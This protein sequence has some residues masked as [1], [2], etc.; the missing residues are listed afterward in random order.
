MREITIGRHPDNKIVINQSDIS[1][2]HAVIEIISDGNVLIKDLNSTN[3]TFVNDVK[4]LQKFISSTDKVQLSN[5]ELD[6][7]SY[8]NSNKKIQVN[9]TIVSEQNQVEQSFSI[10][11]SQTCNHVIPYP[12][13]SSIHA[14]LI[15]QGNSIL[16]VDNQSTNGTYVNGK[17]ILE[18]TLCKGDSLLLSNKYPVDWENLMSF[19]S[20]K[21][22]NKSSL[23]ITGISVAVLIFLG[24]LFHRPLM[25]Q[26]GRWF[27]GIETNVNEKYKNSVVLIY[28]TYLYVLESN[29]G[30][31]YITKDEQGNFCNYDPTTNSPLAISGTG[32]FVS[33]NGDIITNRHVAKP[34]EMNNDMELIRDQ[35]SPYIQDVSS[36]RISGQ[37]VGISIAL[38]DSYV[39]S[40]ND[41]I[42]CVF[43]KDSGD[44]QIDV[45]LL[46]TKT[47]TLPE[48]VNTYID[49]S[50]AVTNSVE[51]KIGEPLFMIGYP[52]GFDLANT[53]QGIMANFQNGQLTRLPDGI[54]FGH[55]LPTMGGASGSPIFNKHGQLMGINYQG[56][57]GTQGFNMAMLAKYVCEL[58][59]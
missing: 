16:V 46:Q 51:I 50:N 57:S 15:R 54:D 29:G 2:H 23:L 33:A 14:K 35:I 25:E 32:F 52:A 18:H 45:A 28:H 30:T 17:R 42:P 34:W 55:N 38:N 53:K 10:G 26:V 19:S 27:P 58:F 11:R 6:L 1:L 40:V 21:T 41:M 43:I 59:N 20:H 39:E 31:L 24:I 5:Y 7:S 22:K 36:V 44:P 3:G 49:L 37:T 12:D 13:V 48:K 8:F 47:K 4:I 56:M 9:S